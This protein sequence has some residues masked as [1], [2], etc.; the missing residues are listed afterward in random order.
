[1]VC[2]ACSQRFAQPVPRCAHCALQV[3]AGARICGA[4]LTQPPAFDRAFAAL[5]Y[6]HPWSNLITQFKF[7]AGLDLAPALASLLAATQAARETPLPS[8]LLPAPLSTQRLRERGY[9]QAWEIT[10]RVARTLGLACDARLLLRITDSPH[11][12]ALP[13]EKRAANVRGAFAVEP[14]RL[15]E[16]QGRTVAVIDDVMT[17]GATMAEMARVLKQAGATQVEAWALARTPHPGR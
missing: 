4:C 6:G 12:L 8:L 5:D 7:H 14:L 15:P 16:L 11:Q 9:N 10:R 17:T 1:M 13:L 2:R 3:P